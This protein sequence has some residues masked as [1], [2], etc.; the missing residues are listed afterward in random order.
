MYKLRTI[1]YH[2]G[3]DKIKGITIPSEIAVFFDKT[4]F[5]VNKSGT[6]IILTSGT[7]SKLTKSEIASFDLESIKL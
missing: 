4:Y 1:A 3:G 7:N 5:S 2:N 6:S